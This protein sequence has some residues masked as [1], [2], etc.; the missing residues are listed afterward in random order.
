MCAATIDITT[1]ARS[2]DSDNFEDDQEIIFPSSFAKPLSVSVLT[3]VLHHCI[4]LL[5]EVPPTLTT[6][7]MT[8]RS[9]FLQVL[10]TH[11]T[12]TVNMF[13]A[14]LHA[15]ILGSSADSDYFEDDQRIIFPSSFV[16]IIYT[17]GEQCP[18]KLDTST[19]GRTT[20]TTLT[21]TKRSYF[22]QVLQHFYSHC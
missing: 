5:L 12:L 19:V 7:R 18:G 20:V 21:M 1:V 22:L 2:A 16:K 6:L 4:L 13:A 3:C 14:S 15:T 9:Y 17:P 8:K 11:T 10:Q